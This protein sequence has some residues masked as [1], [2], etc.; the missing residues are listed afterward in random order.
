MHRVQ[1]HKLNVQ[2]IIMYCGSFGTLVSGHAQ[3]IF[4]GFSGSGAAAGSAALPNFHH[5]ML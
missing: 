4:F 3:Q 1:Q 2:L 5:D